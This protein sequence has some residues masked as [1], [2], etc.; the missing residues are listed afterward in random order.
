MLRKTTILAL[1]AAL[2]AAGGISAAQARDARSF[3]RD[4]PAFAHGR[5]EFR[6]D[7][8]EFR[9]DRRD[10]RNDRRGFGRDRWRYRHNYGR[11]Y[12]GGF[13]RHYYYHYPRH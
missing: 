1:S 3:G 10:F 8:R 7:R 13:Y 2:L 12:D 9:H 4:R 11:W 6:H 5:P